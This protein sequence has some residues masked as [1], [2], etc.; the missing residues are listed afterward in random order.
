MKASNNRPAWLKGLKELA[1]ASGTGLLT[2]EPLAA[3]TSFGIGGEVTALASPRGIDSLV[4]LMEFLRREGIFHFILGR[5]TNLL[6]G[7][8]GVRGVAVKLAHGFG[9][10][11]RLDS[12]SV[13]VGAGVRLAALLRYSMAEGLSGLEFLA[14]I[15]GSVGGAVLLNA[16]A[17][18]TGFMERVSTLSV[19]TA[20]LGVEARDAREVPFSYRRTDLGPGEVVLSAT[21]ALTPEDPARVREMVRERYLAKKRGQPLTERC[22]GCVFKNPAQGV[23]AGK[24]LDLMGFKGA[25]LGGA[26]VSEVHANF[27][28]N[29][30]DAGAGEV[31]GLMARMRDAAKK[32]FGVELEPEIKLVAGEFMG[33][34]V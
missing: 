21:L 14:G 7:D 32:G 4:S 24:L 23:S 20:D 17:W 25:A 6:A 3:H 22:A 1:A 10:V 19:L 33:S 16:G 26:V 18:S 28:V 29:S 2:S 5:G 30:E 9:R 34:P 11:E 8:E 27:I 12:R 15:P 31:I 13:S